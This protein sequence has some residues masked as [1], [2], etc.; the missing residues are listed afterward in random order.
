MTFKGICEN[1]F[2]VIQP[3]VFVSVRVCM[4]CVF[5]FISF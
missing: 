5:S 3:D 1:Y 4:V 2:D